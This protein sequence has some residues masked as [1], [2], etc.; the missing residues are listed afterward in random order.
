MVCYQCEDSD[1]AHEIRDANGERVD[2]S[3]QTRAFLV[4]KHCYGTR[5]PT[6][7]GG[8]GFVAYDLNR[9]R[10]VFLKDYWYAKHE[11]VHPETDV[12]KK[13]KEHNVPNVATL[14][15][16]GDVGGPSAL[17]ET[18]TEEF[19]TSE[20]K[21]TKRRHH[22]F[23]VNEVGRPLETYQTTAQLFSFVLKALTG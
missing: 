10:I 6:G 11:T 13:L 3:A 2:A 15:A 17:Q 9:K 23:V 18:L 14:L 4:G 7:R 16:G 21:P 1:S 5:N 22:R 19:L 20:E 8:K 12:Y